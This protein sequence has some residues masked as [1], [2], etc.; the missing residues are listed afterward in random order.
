M[1]V[2]CKRSLFIN[3]VS[4]SLCNKQDVVQSDFGQFL[5]L[6]LPPSSASC[7]LFFLCFFPIGPDSILRSHTEFFYWFFFMA[8]LQ[9]LLVNNQNL[10][11]IFFYSGLT[12]P[13]TLPH[14]ESL[15][16]LACHCVNKERACPHLR[17]MYFSCN[18]LIRAPG[19]NVSTHLCGSNLLKFHIKIISFDPFCNFA[20]WTGNISPID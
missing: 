2:T 3:T 17:S 14:W 6:S 15:Y 9:I 20:R 11:L 4:S 10:F 7:F 1:G 12:I 18:P 8:I 13:K 5:L 19:N 16:S